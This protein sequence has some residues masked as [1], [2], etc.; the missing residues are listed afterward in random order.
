M[1]DNVVRDGA[2][3][4]SPPGIDSVPLS[5]MVGKPGDT[6]LKDIL[7][8]VGIDRERVDSVPLSEMLGKPG[9]LRDVLRPVGIATDVLGTLRVP[10]SDSVGKLGDS[11][12]ELSEGIVEP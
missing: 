7:G 1:A 4:G 2:T 9:E 8:P 5:E 11:V 3:V 12:G 6:E 10:D